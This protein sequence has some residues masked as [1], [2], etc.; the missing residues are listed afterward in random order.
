MAF[1]PTNAPLPQN[2]L[3]PPPAWEVAASNARL[4]QNFMASRTGRERVYAN[5]PGV[6]SFWAEGPGLAKDAS[7]IIPASELARQSVLN[8]LTPLNNSPAVSPQGL[9]I[10]A[11]PPQVL[12]L[13]APATSATIQTTTTPSIAV[14]PTTST[15]PQGAPIPSVYGYMNPGWTPDAGAYLSS[16]GMGQFSPPW[17]DAFN[18]VPPPVAAAPDPNIPWYIL[19]IILLAAAGLHEIGK[20]E[21]R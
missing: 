3:D 17:S 20:E 10:S 8:G 12:S 15:M 5:M 9:P 1:L 18:S 6:E 11:S 16:D 7:Y 4:Y 13:N 19:G 14:Y 2:S 21:K